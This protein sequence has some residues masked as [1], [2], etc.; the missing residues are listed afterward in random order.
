M[1]ILANYF[2][3][4]NV[5]WHRFYHEAYLDNELPEATVVI[6]N[7]AFEYRDM[8]EY[9]Y[10]LS[11]EWYKFTSLPFVFACWVA[12]KPLP[13]EVLE[14]FNEAIYYG[15]CNKLKSIEHIDHPSLTKDELEDYIENKIDYYFDQEKQKAL[16]LFQSFN[17]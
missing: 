10:D 7:K 11:S 3:K 6:G 5:V 12:N 9:Q 14:Q 15:I 8:Y 1:K 17:V 2:W 16:K 13:A 4:I